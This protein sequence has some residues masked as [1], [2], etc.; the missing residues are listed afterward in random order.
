MTGHLDTIILERNSA[1]VSVGRLPKLW[2]G[3]AALVLLLAGG[4]ALFGPKWLNDAPSAAAYPSAAPPPP[5]TVS[6][7]LQR[8]LADWT[9]FTGQFSAVDYVEIRGP[10]SAAT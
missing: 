10:G 2:A 9:T 5:V 8:D 1:P 4:G 7:P 6:P 3:G